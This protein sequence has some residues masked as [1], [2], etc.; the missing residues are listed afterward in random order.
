L[1]KYH[2]FA[3]IQSFFAE[4]SA[5]L[6]SFYAKNLHFFKVLHLIPNVAKSASLN[7]TKNF[8]FFKKIIRK[9]GTSW[10]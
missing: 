8:T 6:Q 4:K 2:V 10:N 7:M 1:L 3:I 5:I 9:I